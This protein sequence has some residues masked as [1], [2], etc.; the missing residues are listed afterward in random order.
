MVLLSTLLLLILIQWYPP[1]DGGVYPTIRVA[2][3]HRRSNSG[4]LG[5]TRK[6][7][8]KQRQQ[9]SLSLRMLLSAMTPWSP[10]CSCMTLSTWPRVWS[11]NVFKASQAHPGRSLC[12]VLTETGEAYSM[13]VCL[14]G[15]RGGR[16]FSTSGQVPLRASASLLAAGDS[17]ECKVSSTD[18]WSVLVLSVY[19]CGLSVVTIYQTHLLALY[20]TE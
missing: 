2:F 9:L 5:A 4:A 17:Y 7:S 14:G 19:E 1:L 3:R 10:Y 11:A 8:S 18:S 15:C 6:V 16:R 12:M 20:Q 13:A